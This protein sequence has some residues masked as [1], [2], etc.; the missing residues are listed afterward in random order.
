MGNSRGRAWPLA[1]DIVLIVLFAALGRRSHELGL[2][3]TGILFTAAPFL[4]AWGVGAIITRA[5][6]TW[7]NLWPSGVIIWIITV[8]GGLGLRVTIFDETAAISFQMVTATVLG[9]FLLGRR[10]IS[11]LIRRK[12]SPANSQS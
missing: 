5:W 7:R 3:V 10:C 9:F 4:I 2:D 6:K 11:A 1:V 12:S 8:A